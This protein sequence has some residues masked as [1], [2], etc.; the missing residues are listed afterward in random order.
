[1]GY[2]WRFWLQRPG[3]VLEYSTTCIGR[4][5]PQLGRP[6]STG[7][8]GPARGALRDG[9]R[10]SQ[11]QT[12]GEGYQTCRR[13]TLRLGRNLGDGPSLRAL[14]GPR[15]RPG[16]AVCRRAQAPGPSVLRQVLHVSGTQSR[17]FQ[18]VQSQRTRLVRP[19]CGKAGYPFFLC[20][21]QK[22]EAAPGILAYCSILV[23]MRAKQG[24]LLIKG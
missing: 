22:A 18:G 2:R 10:R 20:R 21:Y 16:R 14:Q 23:E 9:S 15:L 1:M 4:A 5:M 3:A 19:K 7:N 11:S 24:L 12:P 8:G 17:L 13:N 6:V